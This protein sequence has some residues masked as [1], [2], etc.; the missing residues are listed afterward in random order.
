MQN[1]REGCLCLNY[2]KYENFQVLIHPIWWTE[3]NKNRNEILNEL[4]QGELDSYKQYVE[5]LRLKYQNYIS[6][7]EKS[8]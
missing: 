6:E 7:L 2:S 4:G 8:N 1:W 5:K 3:D